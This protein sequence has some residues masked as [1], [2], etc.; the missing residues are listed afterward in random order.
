MWLLGAVALGIFAFIAKSKK[1][2]SLTAGILAILCLITWF[3]SG[4]GHGI[5]DWIDNPTGPE[6]PDSVPIPGRE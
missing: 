3:D 1:G 2:I 6:I 4:P 5:L